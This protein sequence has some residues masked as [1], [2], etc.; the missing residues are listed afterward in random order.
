MPLVRERLMLQAKPKPKKAPVKVA[1]PAQRYIFSVWEYEMKYTFF[2]FG[3][4]VLH[5]RQSDCTDEPIDGNLPHK[6]DL[7]T[8]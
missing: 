7:R 6:Q 5:C 8:S 4:Q 2:L 1:A 3:S